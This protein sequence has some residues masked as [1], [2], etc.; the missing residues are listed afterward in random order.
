MRNI[1]YACQILKEILIFSTKFEKY[2]NIIF[3]TVRLAASNMVHA[4]DRHDRK[5]PF[6]YFA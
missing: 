1:R 4:E 6:R 3:M 5:I 2:Q